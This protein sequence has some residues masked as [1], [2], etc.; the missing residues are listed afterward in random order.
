MY[1]SNK[2]RFC[3]KVKIL[4]GIA[5]MIDKRN[6][7]NNGISLYDLTSSDPDM[8]SSIKTTNKCIYRIYTYIKCK[9]T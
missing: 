6:T 7:Q 2:Y 9:G 1:I 4:I 8:T 3:S 5:I